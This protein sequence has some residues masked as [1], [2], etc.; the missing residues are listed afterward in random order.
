MKGK[1][2]HTRFSFHSIKGLIVAQVSFVQFL[3]F[4]EEKF[5]C[6]RKY[7]FLVDPFVVTNQEPSCQISRLLANLQLRYAFNYVSCSYTRT[8]Y[9]KVPLFKNYQIWL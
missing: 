7:H 5:N 4:C 9:P 6:L 3:L 1:I 8:P 2:P